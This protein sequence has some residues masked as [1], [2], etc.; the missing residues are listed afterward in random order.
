MGGH[1]RTS[2][3]KR[4]GIDGFLLTGFTLFVGLIASF[5]AT[6]NISRDYLLD[7]FLLVCTIGFLTGSSL[8]FFAWAIRHNERERLERIA[9]ESVPSFNLDEDYRAKHD[10]SD[11]VI[12]SISAFAFTLF[13]LFSAHDKSLWALVLCSA[14][15]LFSLAALY[16][17]LYFSVLFTDK[18]IAV[19]LKPFIRYFESYGSVTA[20]HF[21][22]GNPKV[23]F[24]DGKSVNL[25]RG[26]GDSQRIAAILQKRVDV[27]PE[28]RWH[29][30]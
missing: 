9:H 15:S 14:F 1:D 10:V 6:I 22:P 20:I 13:A 18:V 21:V 28:E 3:R 11:V 4:K 17:A 2:E 5:I 16:K 24:F 8:F 26:L 23:I 25:G 29:L 27:T 12:F 30:L 19:E 7:K